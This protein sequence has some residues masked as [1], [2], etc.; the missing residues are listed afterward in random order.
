MRK[1]SRAISVNPL[2]GKSF[3]SS[4][5]SEIFEYNNVEIAGPQPKCRV[6]LD[7]M[8][9]RCQ[10]EDVFGLLSNKHC[11]T[12][13]FLAFNNLLYSQEMELLQ[14]YIVSCKRRHNVYMNRIR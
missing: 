3:G 7:R 6:D 12:D 14:N 1:V 10:L 13:I 9:V 11:E 5:F 4:L 2:V 8:G